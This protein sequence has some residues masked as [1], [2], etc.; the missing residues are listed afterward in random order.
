MIKLRPIFKDISLT[1]IAEAIVLVG[2][3][4]IYR[5]LATNFGPEGVGEYSLIRR[6]IAFLQPL[7][8]LGLGVGLPRYIALSK[9]KP[10]RI[11]YL[12]AG[13]LVIATFTLLFLVMVKL[14]S[15]H[16]AKTFF[17]SATQSNLILPFLLL[18]LGL[19]AH[20]ITYSY[21]RG[22]L[23]A[24]KFNLLQIINLFLVPIIILILFKNVAIT[25]IIGLIGITI[26][27]I[28]FIFSLSFIKDFFISTKKW[29]LKSSLKELLRY[30]LPRVPAN[31]ALAGLFSLGPIL[32]AHFTSI[33]EVGYLSVGQSL[34]MGV[35]GIVTPLGIIIL[36]KVSM[37]L[38]EGKEK[39]IK[40]NLCF[41]I[42][43]VFQCSTFACIQLLIFTDSI[44]K[45]WLGS[46]FFAA[47]PVMRIVLIS[48]IF[49]AFYVAMRSVLDAIKVKPINSIN[50]SVSLTMFLS[51][52]GILLFPF[53]LF[54]PIIS[55]SIAFTC[56]LICLGTLTYFSIRR[57]YPET[58]KKDLN[59]LG[60]AIGINLLLGG[61]AV[62]A[63]P[64]II[65][66]IYYLIMFEIFL[67]FIYLSILWLL[68]MEWIRQI[69]KI[70]RS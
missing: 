8:L 43:G 10:Q 68:K 27:I 51:I 47:I 22:G 56:G 45:Y 28:A 40:E 42:A 15:G 69:P 44:V 59:Y 37:L 1:F 49:Y 38:S 35:V 63:K 11:S 24:K 50:L 7:L 57:I 19:I 67:C 12:R 53:K 48:T 30:C 26:F 46:K 17:G 39:T 33:E 13:S 14:F 64:F 5:L 25:K 18:L 60:I 2:F 16:F 58:L 55:L 52:A 6:V 20:N 9:D 23:L 41:F 62:L 34:L 65:S 36:P 3:I 29:Q 32:A 61:I 4:F 70:V 66:R 54:S 31:F 21:F